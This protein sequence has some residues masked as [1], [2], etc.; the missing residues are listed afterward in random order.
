MA[1]AVLRS[2]KP[3]LDL[4]IVKLDG[5]SAEVALRVSASDRSIIARLP[6]GH[7]IGFDLECDRHGRVFAIDVTPDPPLAAHNRQTRNRIKAGSSE[8]EGASISGMEAE[9]EQLLATPIVRRLMQ[10][11]GVDPRSVRGLIRTV[12]R[13]AAKSG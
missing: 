5:R 12:A 13:A 1:T 9:M 6:P 10:K 4:I 7:K 2:F 11:D 8:P 3:E